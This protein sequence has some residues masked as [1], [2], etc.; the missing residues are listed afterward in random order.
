MAHRY[1]W[2]EIHRRIEAGESINCISNSL[3]LAK[4]TI[5]EHYRRLKGRKFALV[6]IN[7][8]PDDVKGE[9]VGAFA[10]DGSFQKGSNYHYVIRF[11]LSP[12]EEAYGKILCQK[13]SLLFSKTPRMWKS[14]CVNNF[15][16]RY[17]SKIVYLWLKKYLVWDENK[18]ATIRLK[19]KIFDYS[20]LFLIG[21]LRG[22]LDTDGYVSRNGGSTVFATISIKLADQISE[23]LSLLN[24]PYCCKV[25]Y[26]RWKPLYTIRVKRSKALSLL[27]I[28]LPS[29][30]KRAYKVRPAG[31]EPAS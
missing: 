3:R 29:N 13:M 18:T 2:P 12:D 20:R 7:E 6:K 21:F 28:L 4:S 23:A 15:V 26:S 11:Y 19:G 8:I 5:F 31:I 9:I 14:S 30:A 25:Y 1:L 17:N 10:G 16:I 24:V 22:C 27:A